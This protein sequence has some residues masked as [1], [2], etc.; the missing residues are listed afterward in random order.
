MR[1][2][3]KYHQCER[4]RENDNDRTAT[5]PMPSSIFPLLFFFW[6][7]FK[8]PR[9]NLIYVC[10]T[11]LSNVM[12]PPASEDWNLNRNNNNNSSRGIVMMTF[13]VCLE[14]LPPVDWMK[15]SRTASRWL[16]TSLA[17]ILPRDGVNVNWLTHT[18]HAMHVRIYTTA[19]IFRRGIFSLSSSWHVND[20]KRIILI[21]SYWDSLDSCFFFKIK[22]HAIPSKFDHIWWWRRK[23]SA[24]F[25]HSTWAIQSAG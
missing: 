9:L 21:I 1:N 3:T 19:D 22:L 13:L 25:I 14:R 4:E 18:V 12:S 23:N 11:M 20:N 5:H 10:V 16:T 6:K 15:H 8:P 17:L 2:K 7:A 24:H